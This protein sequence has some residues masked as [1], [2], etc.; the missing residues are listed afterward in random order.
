MNLGVYDKDPAFAGCLEILT[1]QLPSPELV[2]WTP[3]T[4]KRE[5]HLDLLPCCNSSHVSED[6]QKRLG[7]PRLLSATLLCSLPTQV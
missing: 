4:A 6:F 2:L 1:V 5:N 7:D 3:C